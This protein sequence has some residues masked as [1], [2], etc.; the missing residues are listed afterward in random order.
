MSNKKK[1]VVTTKKQDKLKP[2]ASKI[3]KGSTT[4]K[5][6]EAS[7]TMLFKKKN[8]MWMLAGVGLIAL[9]LFLMSGGKMPDENTWD[10]NRIYSF[11]RITLGPI[12]ILTGLAFQ[13]VAIFK[14]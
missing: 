3:S 7:A 13:I 8:F 2:T 14:K 10:S 5:P 4:V 1:V 11:R 9:G 6:K 12:V